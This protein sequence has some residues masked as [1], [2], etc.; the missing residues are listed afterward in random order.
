MRT[1]WKRNHDDLVPA[2][3]WS[4]LTG[5][6][7]QVVALTTR[8]RLFKRAL[9]RQAS[10]PERS[11]VLDLGCGTGTLTV[12][13]ARSDPTAAI[14]AVDGDETVLR[15]ARRK[16]LN[17]GLKIRFD[18]ALAPALPYPPDSFDRVVSSLFFHHLTPSQKAE[19]ASAVLR[20][21]R[22]GGQFHVADWGKPTSRLM[23]FLFYSVQLLDGFVTTAD[24]VKGVL[25]E[26]IAAAGF[27]EVRVN[28]EIGTPCGTL[29][30]YSAVK[31]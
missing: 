2:L 15:R 9:L 21:L 16:A 31:P 26:I 18:R 30:L 29:A 4:P 20:V 12:Q 5:L 1:P 27:R 23:R 13:L 17:A 11:S 14:T 24:S 22:P 28:R 25:P 10:I 7:D 3:G 8:E 6:Y 19:T